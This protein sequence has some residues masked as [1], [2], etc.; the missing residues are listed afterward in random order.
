MARKSLKPVPEKIEGSFLDIIVPD[1]EWVKV[2]LTHNRVNWVDSKTEAT[3][4][5]EDNFNIVFSLGQKVFAEDKALSS[6]IKDI[7]RLSF[8]PYHWR[9]KS[10]RFYTTDRTG[11]ID[12]KKEILNNLLNTLKE[13]ENNKKDQFDESSE[14]F[15]EDAKNKI[16][17]ESTDLLMKFHEPTQRFIVLAKD[18]LGA[19]KFAML[20]KCSEYNSQLFSPESVS[21]E[22]INKF[23]ITTDFFAEN[24]PNK[25][26]EKKTYFF[27][28]PSYY[29]EI[30]N[31]FILE[32]KIQKEFVEKQKRVSEQNDLSEHNIEVDNVFGLKVKF[33]QDYQCFEFYGKGY[34]ENQDF[35]G[36]VA[37][38]KA[39]GL[40]ALNFIYSED[41]PENTNLIDLNIPDEMIVSKK[42]IELDEVKGGSKREKNIRIPASEWPKIKLIKENFEKEMAIWGREEKAIKITHCEFASLGIFERY[43]A[44]YFDPKGKCFLAFGCRRTGN[45]N[46]IGQSFGTDELDQILY[47]SDIVK[48]ETGKKKREAK[49]S[50]T[51]KSI[52]I[53]FD[54]AK[55][56][57]NEHPFADYI[58]RGT[59]DLNSR[60]HAPADQVII[61]HEERQQVFDTVYMHAELYS[62]T[63]KN[64]PS[65]TKEK[66]MKL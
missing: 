47:S 35:E 52:P 66:R 41:I 1:F 14:I 21:V 53:T 61:N 48:T 50:Q 63:E 19:E 7:C 44:V 58:K 29:E 2:E 26:L 57:M 18:F 24:L 11:T 17:L 60:I 30:K 64:T 59:I 20:R 31:H 55:Y 39:L 32:D 16:Q 3:E 43:P 38:R 49:F 9:E 34:F 54:E 8:P 56:F 25:K 46:V 42:K 40:W 22:N 13:Y 51:M 33:N 36:R 45:F 62:Q 27:I 6:K 23:V 4:K 37:P 65:R 5:V 15:K 10:Y 28:N 12:D